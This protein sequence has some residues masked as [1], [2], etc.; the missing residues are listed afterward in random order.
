MEEILREVKHHTELALN[1][2][3]IAVSKIQGQVKKEQMY[4]ETCAICGDE[5][6]CRFCSF[7]G[8]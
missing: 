2:M 7:S 6:D 1:H 5:G 8:G 3:K 4:R